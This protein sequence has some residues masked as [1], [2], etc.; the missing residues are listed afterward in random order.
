[1]CPHSWRVPR[2]LFGMLTIVPS[3]DIGPLGPHEGEPLSYRWDLR[4]TVLHAGPPLLLRTLPWLVLLVLALRKPN[5]TWRAWPVLIPVA[6][7]SAPL[8]AYLQSLSDI[9]LTEPLLMTPSVVFLSLTL[10]WLSA[11]HLASLDRIASLLAA[12]AVMV[13]PGICL[14]I[15]TLLEV[16]E[17]DRAFVAYAFPLMT[18]VP[19]VLVPATF[20]LA[21]ALDGVLCRKRYTL[22]RF[23]MLLLPS[24]LLFSA[25]AM[26]PVGL[27]EA[28]VMPDGDVATLMIVYGVIAATAI[29]FCSLPYI[30]LISFNSL[31]RERFHAVLRLPG[32]TDTPPH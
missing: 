25:I 7:V 31:Y 29:F 6:V 4:W 28:A 27:L 15:A 21:V 17:S 9:G 16:D 30:A 12:L 3:Q 26:I 22:S 24:L 11:H 14:S 23:R 5:R 10:L 19:M 1:M 18:L 13:F 20:P 2:T 32:M 8:T